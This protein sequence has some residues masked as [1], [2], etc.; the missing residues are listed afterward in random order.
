DQRAH[1]APGP[2]RHLFGC[3][4]RS[5]RRRRGSGRGHGRG[6]GRGRGNSHGT[7]TGDLSSA[8][9]RRSAVLFAVRS[10]HGPVVTR[11]R[12]S[13]TAPQA[14]TIHQP[15]RLAATN[16][17]RIPPCRLPLSTDPITATPSDVPTWRL[18][19]A[20]PAA[21]P[22]CCRGIPDT[23]ELVIGA[24]TRPIPMPKIT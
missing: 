3:R 7:L 9:D 4:R 10:A 24:L 20:T 19:E 14:A 12:I 23:A 21:T 6:R 17:A 1:G 8:G 2:G 18:V 22:A 16:P 13:V 15:G 5:L 11:A